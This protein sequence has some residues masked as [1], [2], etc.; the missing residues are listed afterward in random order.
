MKKPR[1]AVL[2]SDFI[3]VP[4]GPRDVPPGFSGAPEIISSIITDKLVE[5]GYKITLF[6]SGDSKTKASLVS[7]QKRATGLDPKIGEGKHIDFEY[8]LI[9]KCFQMANEGKFDIIHSNFDYRSAFFAP[10]S[11]A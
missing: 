9:S 2:A 4:P 11:S 7:L 10:F 6:A 3:R 1:I 8:A 5:R